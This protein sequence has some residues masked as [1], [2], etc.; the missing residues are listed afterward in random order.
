[1]RSRQMTVKDSIGKIKNSG[2]KRH[3]QD[4]FQTQLLN[5]TAE[6]NSILT[7]INDWKKK[8]TAL[9]FFLSIISLGIAPLIY[10]LWVLL[11]KK[12]ISPNLIKKP[13]EDVKDAILDLNQ[14]PDNDDISTSHEHA[15]DTLREE[16]L[17]QSFKLLESLKST[18]ERTLSSRILTDEQV[19]TLQRI[20]SGDSKTLSFRIFNKNNLLLPLDS[21]SLEKDYTYL[22]KTLTSLNNNTAIIMGHREY[23]GDDTESTHFK[24]YLFIWNRENQSLTQYFIGKTLSS[25][26]HIIY[27]KKLVTQGNTIITRLGNKVVYFDAN[28]PAMINEIRLSDQEVDFYPT[29]NTQIIE[30]SENGREVCYIPNPPKFESKRSYINPPLD[31]IEIPE[32]EKISLITTKEQSLKFTTCTYCPEAQKVY[33]GTNV[34]KIFVLDFDGANIPTS[35]SI[36]PQH[37]EGNTSSIQKIIITNDQRH[38]I[39]HLSNKTLKIIQT[40]DNESL[41]ISPQQIHSITHSYE[42]SGHNRNYFIPNFELHSDLG[43][44]NNERDML[45]CG[46]EIT[47]LVPNFTNLFDHGYDHD[48]SQTPQ[49]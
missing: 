32:V 45:Y 15:S 4:K 16:K 18:V 24:V 48:N 37:H 8:Q 5:N 21:I 12:S 42:N 3:L 34:G 25:P 17:S 41:I 29:A 9:Y 38:I 47:L 44:V 14:P 46:S 36:L 28:N 19:V 35:Y 39:A 27:H 6:P 2:L 30:I 22:H 11:T 1:M 43:F 13:I 23:V 20:K 31:S 49:T 10:A 26:E 40:T 33:L 7:D